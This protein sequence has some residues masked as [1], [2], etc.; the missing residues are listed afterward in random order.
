MRSIYTKQ[1]RVLLK[2]LYEIRA[3]L[4]VVECSNKHL[5]MNLGKYFQLLRFIVSLN[6]ANIQTRAIVHDK[7]RAASKYVDSGTSAAKLQPDNTKRCYRYGV[8]R[9]HLDNICQRQRPVICFG[10]NKPGHRI[11]VNALL[12]VHVT[13]KGCV[14]F[15][16]LNINHVS[17]SALLDTGCDLCLI[18]YNV[19]MMRGGVD[20]SKELQQVKGIGDSL[21]LQLNIDGCELKIIFHVVYEGDII[22]QAITGNNI[23]KLV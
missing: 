16:D 7:I 18:R 6:I 8:E 3:V 5:A 23:L 10:F 15:K 4:I 11:R 20:L 22:Y 12:S 2:F 19:L 14:I 13:P 21:D 17:F 9:G 1:L